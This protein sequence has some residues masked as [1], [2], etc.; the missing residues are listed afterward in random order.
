MNPGPKEK[1][2]KPSTIGFHFFVYP[3]GFARY[4]IK[5]YV[6]YLFICHSERLTME[7]KILMLL[8]FG[9]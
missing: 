2:K 9:F 4:K 6:D 5:V 8:L 3:L 7:Y 1:G